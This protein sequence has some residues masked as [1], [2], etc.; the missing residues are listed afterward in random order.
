MH[1]AVATRFF[2]SLEDPSFDLRI[3]RS[4]WG[5]FVWLEDPLFE[6]RIFCLY[7]GSFLNN[8][9]NASSYSF[10]RSTRSLGAGW[11]SHRRTDG[12]HRPDP[13]ARVQVPGLRSQLWRR[14]RPAGSRAGHRRQGSLQW[15]YFKPANAPRHPKNPDFKLTT[16]W[17]FFLNTS[18]DHPGPPG[19]P[20]PVD[21][22]RDFVELKWNPPFTDG[23]SPITGYVIE[24]REAG[25]AKWIKAADVRGEKHA[26]LHNHL[27]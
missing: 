1:R 8:C 15:G 27:I 7:W 18:S 25:Q 16:L 2:V 14:I 11:P 17:S 6:S 3:L 13:G 12:D 23:G 21:W 9:L 19:I 26:T 4:T 10:V 20:E 22:D 24:K 5:S